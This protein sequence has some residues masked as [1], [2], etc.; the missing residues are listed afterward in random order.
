MSLVCSI[1]GKPPRD[2]VVSPD[3]IVFDRKEVE[4]HLRVS[5][6]CP[7]T[8][9][10]LSEFSLTSVQPL[11]RFIEPRTGTVARSIPA[12]LRVLRM[13]LDSRAIENFNMREAI[14]AA[15]GEIADLRARRTASEQVIEDL[16]AEIADIR[17]SVAALREV[18]T[19]GD[20]HS[21]RRRK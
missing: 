4:Q 9:Q 14:T 5:D 18:E 21:K 3:G 12:M 13:E 15:K 11:P 8:G 20:S 1:S 6:H 17:S 16:L 2:P 19:E 7:I 10:V